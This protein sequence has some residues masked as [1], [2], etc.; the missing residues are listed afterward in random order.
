M[1]EQRFGRSLLQ[2]DKYLGLRKETITKML[3]YHLLCLSKVEI[4]VHKNCSKARGAL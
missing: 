2:V 1:L 3:V 4:H